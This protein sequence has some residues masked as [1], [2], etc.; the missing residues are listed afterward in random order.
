MQRIIYQFGNLAD[1]RSVIWL[2]R[3][4][5]RMKNITIVTET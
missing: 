5:R 1:F 4:F 3:E 2:F